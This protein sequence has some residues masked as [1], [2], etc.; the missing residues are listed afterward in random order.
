[1]DKIL[2]TSSTPKLSKLKNLKNIQK[3]LFLKRFLNN[4]STVIGSAIFLVIFI[5]TIF[6]N[7]LSPY[8]P[9]TTDV[10]NQLKAP[11]G[12]FWFGTDNFGRDL[13]SRILYGIR[14]SVIVGISTTILSSIIGL[15]IGLYASYYKRLDN[16]L[17]RIMDGF[18]AFPS[19]LLAIA[20]IAALGAN[21]I[22]LIICLTIVFV[23]SVARIVRSAAL[24]SKE[25]L[26]VQA[27]VSIGASHTRIIW[28]HIMPNTLSVLIIQATFVFAEA[29]IVEAALSFL[30][31]GVPEPTASLGNLLSG[32]KIYIYNSWWITLF[33]GAALAIVILGAYLLGDG[34]RDL[35][36]SNTRKRKAK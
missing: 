7:L 2:E 8:D 14:I 29:I 11:N 25:Q 26:Y 28:R 27:M 4:K 31:A 13:F 22:N 3:K 6:T 35:M 1:M 23:P 9:N 5:I 16:L 33:S 18:M 36:D 15:V 20:I 19:T 17:M 10:Y 32:G 21:V 30:G 12:D 34:L 24:V